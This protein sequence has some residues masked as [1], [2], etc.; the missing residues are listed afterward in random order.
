MTSPP[1][2]SHLLRQEVAR[3]GFELVDLR[4]GGPPH[5]RSVRVR[6]DRPASRPGTGVTSD[7]CVVVARALQAW[8]PKATPL[9][10]VESL[11]VSSPGIE[12][13][14]RWP[15]HWRRYVGSRVRIRAA[16][17]SGRPVAT[18]EDVPDEAHVTLAIEQLGSRTLALDDIK[19]ATLVVDWPPGR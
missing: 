6:I 13:P 15:E 7:D 12:R 10:T 4:L 16:G 11:E 18:I 19:E 3:L 8:F 17:V 9:E 1:D 5:R 14:I 2:I